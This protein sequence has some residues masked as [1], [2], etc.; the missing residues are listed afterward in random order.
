M[1]VLKESLF[2]FIFS[3]DRTLLPPNTLQKIIIQKIQVAYIYH[4]YIR[5][6]VNL[7]VCSQ[8][9]REIRRFKKSIVSYLNKELFT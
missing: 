5:T 9:I 7:I 3:E 1:F 6:F 4:V 2:F 8:I